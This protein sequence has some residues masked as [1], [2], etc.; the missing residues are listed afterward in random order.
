MQIDLLF[1]SVGKQAVAGRFDQL[2]EIEGIFVDVDLAGLDL[3]EVEDLVDDGPQV[4]GG[5]LD[6]VDVAVLVVVEGRFFQQVDETLDAVD[7][8]ADLVAHV[9]QELGFHLVGVLG[10]VAGLGQLAVLVFEVGDRIHQLQGCS[11]DLL[12]Q[13]H[14]VCQQRLGHA[15]EALLDL[16]D[17]VVLDLLDGLPEVAGLDLLDMPQQAENRLRD[18]SA[19]DPGH[20]GGQ[21]QH[22]DEQYAAAQ[23]AL[24][25]LLAQSLARQ[26]EVHAADGAGSGFLGGIGI[27]DIEQIE[28]LAAYHMAVVVIIVDMIG[29]VVTRCGLGNDLA[30]GIVDRQIDHIRVAQALLEQAADRIVVARIEI[31]FGGAGYLLCH[32]LAL[33]A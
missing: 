24:A 14:A 17:L 16:A 8:G 1:Q 6:D 27:E 31:E 13:L 15:V 18:A 23:E 21:Q 4:A 11:L 30:A 22:G 26:V 2:V 20:Q 19:D 3:G 10:L 28:T 7:R 32:Q 5:L 33:A 12:V 9:G 25:D 29:P